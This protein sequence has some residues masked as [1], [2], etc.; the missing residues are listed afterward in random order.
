MGGACP[1]KS[2]GASPLMPTKNVFSAKDYKVRLCASDCNKFQ[3]YFQIFLG[4]NA[5]SP[6]KAACLLC[7]LYATDKF[8]CPS[9]KNL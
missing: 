5:R 1:L 9:T 4:E 8:P 6:N 3:S 7:L 2:P